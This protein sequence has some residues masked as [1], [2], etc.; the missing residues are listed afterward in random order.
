M[1]KPY[2]VYCNIEMSPGYT[3]LRG[4]KME[5]YRCSKCRRA[6][7]TEEQSNKALIQMEQQRLKKQYIKKPIK[8]G[9]SWGLTFP[10][11]IV[12][13]F[14]LKSKKLKL[15]PSLEKGKI[16]IAVE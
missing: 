12:L 11:E 6:V 4:L 15:L 8:I 16:E 10:K 13:A 1:K 14:N 3:R 9:S 2:C 7:L 5:A